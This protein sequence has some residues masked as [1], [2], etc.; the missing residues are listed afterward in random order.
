MLADEYVIAYTAAQQ[1]EGRTAAVAWQ[2]TVPSRDELH[3]AKRDALLR[4]AAAA[5]SRKGFHATSLDEIAQTL[6][7]TKAA[8][9]YYF[10]NKQ[11]LLMACFEKA[12]DVAFASYAAAEREGRNGRE[13]LRLSLAYYLERM[14]DQL[15][16][17]VVLLEENALQPADHA[18]M[19]ASRDR[20]ERALRDLVREG[21]ADGS[22]VPCDPKLAVFVV[23]GAMNWVSKWFRAD[24]AWSAR[25]LTRAMTDMFDRMLDTAPAAS[26]TADVGSSGGL[27]AD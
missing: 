26:L 25:Q 5:F 23:L 24:G 14:L 13:K 1:D 19:V 7:V 20:F 16:A 22:I 12:M 21:I 10:P 9:Y 4:A 3:G 11:T 17:C 18:R 27:P 6:G 8:L 2:N 15:N